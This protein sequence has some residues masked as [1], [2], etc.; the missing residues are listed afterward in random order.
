[1]INFF[2]PSGL[3]SSL[4]FTYFNQSGEFE[5]IKTGII[6]PG[7]DDFWI[8]DAAINYRL[9]K[10]Y[11]FLSIGDSHMFDQKFNYFDTD[12]K[13]PSILPT[14]MAFARVTLA[15]P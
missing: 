12:F 1:M 14:R 4:K 15:F 11:G 2:H 10:R 8:V 13:N 9:H 6:S 5:S 3:G 7:H